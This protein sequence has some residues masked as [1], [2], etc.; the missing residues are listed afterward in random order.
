MKERNRIPTH[1][2]ILMCGVALLFDFFEIL[3]LVTYLAPPILGAVVGALFDIMLSLFA[4]L[5]FWLWFKIRGVEISDS[6]K[7]MTSTIAMWVSEFTPLGILPIWTASVV[8]TTLIVRYDDRKY[9]QEMRAQLNLANAASQVPD[10]SP[11]SD[12]RAPQF[13]LSAAT[14]LGEKAL[15]AAEG[16][17]DPQGIDSEEPPTRSSARI[18]MHDVVAPPK[19]SSPSGNRPV[20]R[21][22]A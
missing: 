17:E 21:R 8:L 6:L 14:A 11:L 2:F 18:P 4:T 7:K 15:Q 10:E 22:N 5:T 20:R 3:F 12:P 16:L 13:I 1:T 19:S 9:N